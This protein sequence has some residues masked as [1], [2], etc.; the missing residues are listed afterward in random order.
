MPYLSGHTCLL[1]TN[2][3]D[4]GNWT[5]MFTNNNQWHELSFV[6]TELCLRPL[7]TDADCA[8]RAVD[9]VLLPCGCR[10]V[11]ARSRRLG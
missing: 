2:Q 3:K 11:H 8:W 9:Y 4:L 10:K 5:W 6:L 1:E 7:G